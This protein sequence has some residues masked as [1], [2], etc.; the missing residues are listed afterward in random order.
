MLE[1]KQ[2]KSYQSLHCIMW[3]QKK[4]IK[5]SMYFFTFSKLFKVF[6]HQSL[7]IHLF[8]YC[9]RK[10]L[11][12]R[13]DTKC[14]VCYQ[15][16]FPIIKNYVKRRL[17]C[18]IWI[19][20]MK[21][22]FLD[23]FFSSKNTFFIIPNEKLVVELLNVLIRDVWQNFYLGIFFL[24]SSSIL[25]EEIVNQ[26]SNVDLQNLKIVSFWGSILFQNTPL[27]LKSSKCI[28][29]E[30]LRIISVILSDNFD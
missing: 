20:N 7:S 23:F 24:K 6:T 30:T 17:S 2:L 13:R 25:N 19:D 10:M 4:C 26:R 28:T 9:T 14:S 3:R 29:L 22:K 12:W 27:N 21:L 1:G 5:M 15:K 18:F 16:R 8:F 11:L